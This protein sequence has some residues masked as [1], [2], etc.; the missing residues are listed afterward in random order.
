M[1]SH[2][3]SVEEP[4]SKE[5]TKDPLLSSSCSSCPVVAAPGSPFIDVEGFSGDEDNSGA[6]EMKG[7]KMKKEIKEEGADAAKE[8]EEDQ[9]VLTLAEQFIAAMPD[10]I[11]VL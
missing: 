9:K 6:E 3:L 4:N 11:K 8:E 2:G 1:T 5:E 7:E 10:R